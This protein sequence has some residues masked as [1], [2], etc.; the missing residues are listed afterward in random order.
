MERP[1]LFLS[2]SVTL[3][4]N[5]MVACFVVDRHGASAVY[6]CDIVRDLVDDQ[7]VPSLDVLKAFESIS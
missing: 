7:V 1:S 3:C 4:D 5:A 6:L 2:G